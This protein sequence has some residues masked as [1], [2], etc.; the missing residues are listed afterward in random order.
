MVDVINCLFSTSLGAGM[1]T[2]MYACLAVLCLDYKL[3]K[4][5]TLHIDP[6]NGDLKHLV[7]FVS[8]LHEYKLGGEW[9]LYIAAILSYMYMYM[10]MCNS[11]MYM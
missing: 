10:Y 9:Y 8:R 6:L 1:D 7:A 4:C 2:Y 5:D 11:N 3:H